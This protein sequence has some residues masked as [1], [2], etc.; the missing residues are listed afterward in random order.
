MTSNEP[1]TWFSD[2][3]NLESLTTLSQ[4]LAV[5]GW[6]GFEATVSQAHDE[7]VRARKTIAGHE[8]SMQQLSDDLWNRTVT[9]LRDLKL[10]AGQHKAL[11]A[12]LNAR[13][14]QV[15]ESHKIG[16]EPNE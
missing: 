1:E 5:E 7:L 9:V 6:G 15:E 11:L 3:Q 8:R 10:N 12:A 13:W 4:L 14:Q 2:V 16:A